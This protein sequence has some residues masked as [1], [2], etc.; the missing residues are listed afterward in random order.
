MI[1]EKIQKVINEK[2]RPYLEGHNGDIKFLG[3][4][5]GIV[6]IRLLGQCSSCASAKYTVED[7]VETSLIS[8]I[9]EVKKVELVNDVSEEI[10][11]M[12]RR[13]LNKNM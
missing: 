6:K 3:I 9:P 8:E 12:A 5:E 10:L 13:I 11:D 4:E 7:V 2:V 1:E